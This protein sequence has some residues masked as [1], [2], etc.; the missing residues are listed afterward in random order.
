MR[1]SGCRRAGRCS[2]RPRITEVTAGCAS[3]HASD[4]CAWLIPLAFAISSTGE[5]PPGT[6]LL[7]ARL[8]CLHSALGTLAQTRGA[9]RVGVAVVLAG[10]PAA[11]ERRPRQQ[12]DIRIQRGG[13]DLGLDLSHEQA[14]L[15]LERH[16]R[17]KPVGAPRARPW[18][19]ASRGS[20]RTR[21]RRSCHCTRCR[22]ETAAFPREESRHPRHASE[23]GR[24]ARC[25]ADAATRRA[26]PRWRAGTCRGPWGPRSSRSVPL[27]RSPSA[28]SPQAHA[29]RRGG[30]SEP[31][32]R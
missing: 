6:H 7:G 9:R 11:R 27:W 12:T 32:C 29:V 31:V 20:S 23:R 25:P 26:R 1:L 22:R 16:G 8:P 14:V 21:S 10:E 19:A 2:A 24:S 30:P 18:S 13:H 5:D 15:R 28:R 17:R 4:T 3:S